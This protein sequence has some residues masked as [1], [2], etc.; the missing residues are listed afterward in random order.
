MQQLLLLH[1]AIGSSKHFG[2]ILPRLETDFDVQILDFSGHG[3]KSIPMED[4]SIQLF[5]KDVLSWQV[6]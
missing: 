6:H 2:T 4:F 1:G 3:G 5:A